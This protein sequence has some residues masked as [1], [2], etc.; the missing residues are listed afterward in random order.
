MGG[1]NNDARSGR[2]AFLGSGVVHSVAVGVD[3]WDAQATLDGGIR[4]RTPSRWFRR[5]ST[6]RERST[7]QAKFLSS[8]GARGE[9]GP[10]G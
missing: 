2:G 3:L 4:G 5:M 1:L 9:C 7:L 8:E 10:T 6:V